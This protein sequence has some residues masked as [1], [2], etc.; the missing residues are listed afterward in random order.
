MYY[1]GTQVQGNTGLIYLPVSNGGSGIFIEGSIV[2]TQNNVFSLGFT[3]ARW[4]D[5]F[6]GPGTLNIAGPSG[7]NATIGSDQNAIVYTQSGFATPFINIGPTINS[8]DPG[9]IGGWV[10]G[11]TGTLGASDYDL[12]AQQK[13]PGASV[14]AGL[15]GPIYSLTHPTTALI[16]SGFTGSLQGSVASITLGNG[17]GNAV[18]LTTTTIT[19]YSPSRLWATVDIEYITTTASTHTVSFY[20]TVDSETSNTTSST[21]KGNGESNNISLNH[22][23]SVK[24]AGT[25]TVTVYGYAS[26]AAAANV[27]HTDVFV[28]GNLA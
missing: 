24:S 13:L 5:V 15:T 3:G 6:M 28:M 26:A 4:A 18:V 14:P 20:M 7:A 8:L 21:N 9:A 22:R 19:I 17:S 25:Y 12:T 11:P 10:L 2:P 16:Q 23:T 1:D 27:N